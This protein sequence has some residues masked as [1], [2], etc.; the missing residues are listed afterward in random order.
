MAYQPDPNRYSM[1]SYTPCGHSGIVLPRVS[2]GLWHNFGADDNTETAEAILLKAFDRGVTCFDLANNYGPP[3]GSAEMTLGRLLHDQLGAW[4]DELIITTKAG[5]RMWVGPYGDGSSR[6]NLMASLNQSL[7]RLRLDYVDIF[8][9]HRYDGVT[10]LE[11]TLQALVDVVKAGKALYVGLSKYPPEVAE[12]A[13]A[14]LAEQ[15]T[16]C[17]IHQDRYSLLSRGVEK[18]VLGTAHRNGVGFTA[19]SPLAQGLLTNRYLDGLPADSRAAR[20]QFL[21]A[22][23]LTPALLSALRR[24]NEIAGQRGETLAQMALSWILHDKRVTSVIIGASSVGQLL[25]NLGALNAAPFDQST[26]DLL[27]SIVDSSANH[28]HT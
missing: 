14:Y 17:L 15:N 19:F 22:E 21:K 12:K 8:Y 23:H 4:R 2:L 24:L 26:L 3:P 10:P 11:E 16:P 27:D 9:S 18:G 5:H 1:M 7:K 25:D 6:K 20:N 13:Y 28:P